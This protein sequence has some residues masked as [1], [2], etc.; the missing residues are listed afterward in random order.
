M[1]RL[2]A[3]AYLVIINVLPLTSGLGA[4]GSRL[5]TGLQPRVLPLGISGSTILCG[6][7]LDNRCAFRGVEESPGSK[8]KAP[9]NTW[10]T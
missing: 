2:H 8:G 1:D 3:G 5:A 7:R 10:G 9:G 6:S 4:W